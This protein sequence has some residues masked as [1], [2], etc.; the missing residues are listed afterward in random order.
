M[1]TDPTTAELEEISS[2]FK[3]DIDDLKAPLDE[4]ERSRIDVED[5]YTMILVDIPM[6]EERNGKDWYVT[7]PLGITISFVKTTRLYAELWITRLLQF[8]PLSF[9]RSRMRSAAISERMRMR[10]A[11]RLLTSS[12]FRTV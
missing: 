5:N 6:T 7:V 4:E 12:I 2:Y 3:M 9:M 11:P 8:S 10:A 1:M